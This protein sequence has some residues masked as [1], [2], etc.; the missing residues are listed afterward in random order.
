MMYASSLSDFAIDCCDKDHDHNQVEEQK[1]YF[2]L[3]L[4]AIT[5]GIEALQFSK[6]TF[7]EGSQNLW[8]PF[9]PTA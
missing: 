8:S 9:Q 6:P 1:S 3:Q 5:D 7:D 2:T 4:Q